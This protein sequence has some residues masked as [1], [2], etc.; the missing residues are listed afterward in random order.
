[1]KKTI[2]IIG[3]GAAGM[4]AAIS[5]STE[6]KKVILLEHNEK[7]GK[8]I[9]IT[10]KGRCN[11]TNACAPDEFLNN[12]VTNKRFM[13]G[14]FSRFNNE[15]MMR[16]LEK[17]GLKIKTERGQRVFPVSDRSSDVIGVLKRACEKAGVQIRY[18]AHVKRINVRE[19]EH[20]FE[21]VE[22]SDH[23][24]IE[25]DSLIIATGGVSY[26]STGSDGSGYQLAKSIGHTIVK[27]EPSLVPF[28]MREPWCRDLM[29]LTL[30][31]IAIKVKDG[32]KVVYEGFGEFLFTHFG[33]SG[34][35]VLTASTRLGKYQKSL[36]EGKLIL[37]L[38]LK[39]A[40]TPEQLDKRL[41]RE[42]DMYRNKNVSNVIDT[43]VPKKMSSIILQLCDIPEDKKVRDLSKKDRNKMIEVLKNITLHISGI[44]GFQ[45]AI[46]TRGGVKT[47]EVDPK[48]MESKLVGGVYF[49][50]EIL[51]VDAVTGGFNLQI[52]WST[53]YCAGKNA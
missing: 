30:K 47:K 46:I 48:T 44:R 24:V 41:L 13:Y 49:A 27:P 3:G 15:D 53:G 6:N 43:L 38:D 45:E 34:P 26:Q 23:T 16:Y 5:A 10:G 8:K 1:M 21:S 25:G 18:H 39:P 12:V 14:S 35:L 36:Q 31:N 2:I 9:F 32:K 28:E 42:F 51:D 17:Q 52:A 33:V 4:M 22:L 11:I 20:I 37:Q 50:G 40:L 7:L 19:P 29:G